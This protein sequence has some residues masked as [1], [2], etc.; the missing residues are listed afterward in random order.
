MTDQKK[1]IFDE[2]AATWDENPLRVTLA[3]D[4]ADAIIREIKPTREMDALDYGC[5]TGLVTLRLQPFVKSITGVDS[6]SG[7]L[8]VIK[9]KVK[10]QGLQNVRTQLVDFEQ[11]GKVE[12]KFHLVVSCM[13]MHHLREP[14]VIFRPLYDLLLPGGCLGIIDLDKE[15]G[16]FHDDNTGVFHFGF[17]RAHVKRLLEKTG[18]REVRDIT[19][20][21]V[22]KNVTGKG[23]R[24]FPVF[25]IVGKPR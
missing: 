19:A 13:T 21:T 6:S 12:G 10:N 24:K 15:D 4:V 7:M 16:L 11:S 5:G 8:D 18:F 17:D 25:L 23:E 3:H 2:R 14:G 22:V 9:E 1:T 20:A